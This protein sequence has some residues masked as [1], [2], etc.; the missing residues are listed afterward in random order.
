MPFP[1]FIS[2][3][4]LPREVLKIMEKGKNKLYDMY[5]LFKGIAYYETSQ[6]SYYETYT[7][8]FLVTPPP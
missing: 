1:P 8:L 3:K 4:V 5:L 6:K 2:S 7:K